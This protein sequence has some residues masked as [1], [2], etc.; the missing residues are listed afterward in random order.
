MSASGLTVDGLVFTSAAAAAAIAARMVTIL[1]HN[2]LE[3]LLFVD[4]L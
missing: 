1:G 2:L 4:Y 3:D